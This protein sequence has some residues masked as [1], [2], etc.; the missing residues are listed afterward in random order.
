MKK[1][2]S[3]DVG[4]VNLG[5]CYLSLDNDIIQI[6][7][8]GTINLLGEYESCNVDKCVYQAHLF[9]EEKVVCTSCV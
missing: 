3:F 5:Y 7:E 9:T 6:I 8:W 1:F 4:I 2:L